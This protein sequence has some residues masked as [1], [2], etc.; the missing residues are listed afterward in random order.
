[1]D[2]PSPNLE[3]RSQSCPS[4]SG[5]VGASH[6]PRRWHSEVG[7]TAQGRTAFHLMLPLPATIAEL[8]APQWI[9][10]AWFEIVGSNDQR[11]LRAGTGVDWSTGVRAIDPV[12]TARYFS[13]YSA[14]GSKHYQHI[15]PE[16]WLEN[17]GSGRFWSIWRLKPAEQSVFISYE[18]FIEVR[19]VLQRLDRSKRR[20]KKVRV[21]RVDRRTGRIYYRSVNRRSPNRS[22]CQSR[23][24]G[25]N[26]FVPNGPAFMTDL[27]RFIELLENQNSQPTKGQTP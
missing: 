26:Q 21:R 2:T 13:R 22:F 7:G 12:R 4:V 15:V 6:W 14:K 11:H 20:V 10:K 16:L 3:E 25:G 17:G 18:A 24:V 5:A 1:M 9:S 19:R 8:P 27:G 23:I